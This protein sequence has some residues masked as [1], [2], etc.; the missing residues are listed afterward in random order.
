VAV[1]LRDDT[2]SSSPNKNE[3]TRKVDAAPLVL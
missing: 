2:V 1:G 3:A